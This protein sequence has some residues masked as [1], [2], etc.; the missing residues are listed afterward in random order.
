MVFR[1][2]LPPNQAANQAANQYSLNT[3][4]VPGPVLD[5]LAIWLKLEHVDYRGKNPPL[6]SFPL[7]RDKTFAELI[8]LMGIWE[9]GRCSNKRIQTWIQTLVLPLTSKF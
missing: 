4:S 5:I 6:I 7:L 2:A 8:C 1:E 3:C 9:T